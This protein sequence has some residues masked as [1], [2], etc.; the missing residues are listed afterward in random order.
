[1]TVWKGVILETQPAKARHLQGTRAQSRAAIT[2]QADIWLLF[3]L[4]VRFPNCIWLCSLLTLNPVPY[5][6]QTPSGT[7]MDI[8]CI[9]RMLDRVLFRPEPGVLTSWT[10]CFTWSLL[11][12]GLRR[13]I[14]TLVTCWN[15][16]FPMLLFV[17]LGLV[18]CGSERKRKK[19][20]CYG[21]MLVHAMVS[22][23]LL[24]DVP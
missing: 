3:S 22:Q 11:S 15:C 12:N 18:L 10:M 14:T 8:N 23:Q 13:E 16:S 21:M 4:A 2:A 19:Q 5:R 20:Q 7:C 6:A 9:G 17:K 1:M 24:F